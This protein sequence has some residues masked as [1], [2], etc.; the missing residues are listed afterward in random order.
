MKSKT[1]KMDVKQEVRFAVVMYGGVSLA[2]YINGVAQ[3]LLQLVRATA[4]K[5]DGTRATPLYPN[6]KLSGAGQVYRQLGQILGSEWEGDGAKKWDPD[7]LPDVLALDDPTPGVPPICTRFVI[8]ILS[9]TSAGGINAVFLAKALANGQDMTQLQKLWV[10]EG[11]IEKLINDKGAVEDLAGKGLKQQKPPQSLLSGQRMYY[12]LVEAF[13]SM[14]SED[15]SRRNTRSPYVEELSLFVTATD[16]NGLPIPLRLADDVVYERRHRN[17]FQFQYKGYKGQDAKDVK[18]DFHAGNN[19]LLAFAAR[20]TSSFPFAFEPMRLADID[21]VLNAT[22]RPWRRNSGKEWEHWLDFFPAYRRVNG[23]GG[24]NF[25]ERAFADGGYLDNKPFGYA[26]DAL[27]TR[28]AE[29]PV[30]RKLIYIEPNPESINPNASPGPPPNAIENTLLAL[31]KLPRYETIR[32]DLQRILDRNRRIGRVETLLMGMEEDVAAFDYGYYPSKEGEDYAALYLDDMIKLD[33]MGISYGGYHRLKVSTVTDE[34]AQMITRAAGFD[35]QS[36]EFLAIRYLIGAWRDNHFVRYE[37]DSNK[38]DKDG[39]KPAS[40]NKFLSQYD[41]SYRLRRLNFVLLKIDQLDSLDFKKTE[42]IL[43]HKAFL[44]ETLGL[45][46]ILGRENLP[47]DRADFRNEL[48]RLRK[49]LLPYYLDLRRKHEALHKP[50][51]V[52]ADGPPLRELVTD[53][54]EKA[55]INVETLHQI[56][57]EATEEE[58]RKQANAIYKTETKTEAFKAL[59]EQ[60]AELIK[61]TTEKASEGCKQVLKLTEGPSEEIPAEEVPLENIPPWGRI[62]YELIRDY[63][64]NYDRYDLMMFPTMHMAELGQE[65]DPVEVLRISP[66]DACS[67]IDERTSPHRKLAGTA[68]GN[69]GAF[70]DANWRKND[71]LWGRLDGA[72]R[73]ISALIKDGVL[74]KKLIY[75]AHCAILAEWEE[76]QPSDRPPQKPLKAAERSL[77]QEKT[78]SSETRAKTELQEQLEKARSSIK[79]VD[80]TLTT[81]GKTGLQTELQGKVRLAQASIEEAESALRKKMDSQRNRRDLQGDEGAKATTTA[82]LS[83]QAPIEP[84]RL[85]QHSDKDALYTR[86]KERHRDLIARKLNTELAVRSIARSTKV[87][88]HLFEAIADAYHISRR[89]WAWL[90]KVGAIFSGLVEV[91]VPGNLFN[92]IFLHWLRLLYLTEGLLIGGSILLGSPQVQKFGWIA[93]LLTLA[94]NLV[95]WWLG[96][97]MGKRTKSRW[98]RR[99]IQV[100]AGVL[101]GIVLLLAVLGAVDVAKRFDLVHHWQ[102]ISGGLWTWFTTDTEKR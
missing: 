82:D 64:R 88:G 37:K 72:E 84:A 51:E 92:L 56:L 46:G 86:F 38:L 97:W 65:I 3:E 61:P 8:D 17:V 87:I 74:R 35:E 91:A 20:C 4:Q 57:K 96:D 62:A 12:K 25:T 70:L 24:D 75:K 14:E 33:V 47:E 85:P 50:G 67:I 83:L 39:N 19:A 66:K 23:K 2:I 49:K 1:P 43:K 48:T 63:Y 42:E 52:P 94:V 68:L 36:D 27:A 34:I 40:E 7:H 69:F 58:R 98:L 99:G 59:A 53:F 95:T 18:N 90:A 60:L 102:R 77:K 78:K 89:P 22:G 80:A 30:D 41:L 81:W 26:I 11:D 71:I 10:E 15:Y 73:I 79:K 28:S 54:V 29:H 5:E 76:S 21:A 31:S 93:L 101:I 100:V 45:V 13:D 6:E 44:I 55:H 32:E 9:G 16:L